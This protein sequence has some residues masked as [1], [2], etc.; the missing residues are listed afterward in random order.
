MNLTGN[1]LVTVAELGSGLTEVQ[2]SHSD[3]KPNTKKKDRDYLFTVVCL[4]FVPFER[5]NQSA[6]KVASKNT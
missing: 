6:C 5:I 2:D 3:L 4:R 1:K